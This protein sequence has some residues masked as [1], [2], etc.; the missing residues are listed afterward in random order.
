MPTLDD[1]PTLETFTGSTGASGSN[2]DT[3]VSE[4]DLVNIYDVSLGR[5][6]TISLAELKE[7]IV[8]LGG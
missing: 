4:N 8:A 6:K 1:A 3:L 7:A 5:V 2:S